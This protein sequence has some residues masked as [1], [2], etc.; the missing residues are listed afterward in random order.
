MAGSEQDAKIESAVIEI[1]GKIYEG[2]NQAE[3][4]LK[5]KAD[6]YRDWETNTGTSKWLH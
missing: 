6:A 5:A 1:G 2:K 4:I 3:A